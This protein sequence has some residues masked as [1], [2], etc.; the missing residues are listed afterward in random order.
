VRSSSECGTGDCGRT[1]ATS[2]PSTTPSPPSTRPSDARG[3]RSSAFVRE[4]LGRASGSALLVDHRCRFGSWRSSRPSFD[5]VI[6][7]GLAR[8]PKWLDVRFRAADGGQRTLGSP[9]PSV[10]FMSTRPS[11]RLPSSVLQLTNVGGFETAC[12]TTDPRA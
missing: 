3:R 10:D 1:S 5:Y 9:T 8:Q 12:E 11:A 6:W 2:R 4:D 7:L